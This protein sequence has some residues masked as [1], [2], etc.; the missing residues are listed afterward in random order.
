MGAVRHAGF[1]P[2]DDDID[3]G[4]MRTEAERLVNILKN[5]P[6]VIV[7]NIFIN[8]REN[9]IHHV[10]Q[11][12]WKHD[13]IEVYPSSIDVFLYDYCEEEPCQKNWD[14]WQKTKKEAVKE[15][16]LYPE[17]RGYTKEISDSATQVKLKKIFSK[18]YETVNNMLGVNENVTDTIVFVF[19]NLDYPYQDVHMFKKNMVFPVKKLE[20]EGNDFFVPNQYMQY[21]NPIYE[22]I[23]SLPSDMLSHIHVKMDFDC[24]EAINAVYEKY[25]KQR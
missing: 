22:D 3:I 17:A 15:S 5:E 12:F 20:Y 24:E 25:G 2:W 19:Y 13:K 8:G 4:M 10:C 11:I 21:L 23:Y 6:D 14:F 1:I 16:E 9:G 18:Y 7:R